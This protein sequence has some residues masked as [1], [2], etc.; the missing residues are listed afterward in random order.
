MEPVEPYLNL[1]YEVILFET[2]DEIHSS[3]PE[4]GNDW[5]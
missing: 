3:I 1:E 4:G 5:E 2:K